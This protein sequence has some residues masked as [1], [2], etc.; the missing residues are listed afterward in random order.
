MRNLIYNAVQC[1]LIGAFMI[2]LSSCLGNLDP[3]INDKIMPE[4]FFKSEDDARAAVTAIYNPFGPN[5][6]QIYCA[7]VESPFNISNLTTDDMGLQRNDIEAVERFLWTST[8]GAV[9]KF[10]SQ[11]IKH[12]S[13]ATL[14]MDDLKRT[15]MNEKTKGEFIAEVQCA[16]GLYMFWLYD[17]YGTAGVVLDPE[18]LRNPEQEVFLERLPKDEFVALIE[19]DLKEAAAAL[20]VTYDT[21]D[22][23][24]FT[25]GA[26]YA[27][28]AKLYMQEKRWQEAEAI[29]REIQKFGYELQADYSSIFAVENKRNKEII[30]AIPCLAAGVGNLWMTEAVPPGY[31]LQNTR[32]Q[33]WNVYNTPWRFYGKYEKGDK[34]L[35]RLIGEFYYTPAGA[36][37]PVLADRNTFDLFERG[38]FPM[39]YPEDPAQTGTMSSNDLVVFRYAD[40]LLELAEI[41][42]EQSG[43]TAE[44][45]SY[46]EQIRA[47]AG[48]PN[49]IPASATASK[50]AFRD[51][52]L[53]ESGRELFC[54]GHRRRNLIRH[55]KFISTA[56]ED[57]Y[58]TAKDH[59]V[60][61]PLPQNILDES[62][63]KIKQNPGY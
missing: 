60:L 53:D 24:R 23:G 21:K 55:G 30:W 46:V 38:C 3:V 16:R 10:Y 44:A 35:E 48:L 45:V 37:K 31:P 34:R 56:H 59:M 36:V 54:E 15:P 28:L 27:V 29:S 20:P 47:R 4:N 1:L 33:R 8:T 2:G 51:Y 43:P 19:K 6:D 41:I 39:K 5:W 11:F 50:D 13:R 57:G 9:N 32:T 14:L 62:K 52:L 17:F 58:T 26:A 40:V 25:K 7:Q 18:I 49:S 63:G 12:V 42:N 61:F 22:W